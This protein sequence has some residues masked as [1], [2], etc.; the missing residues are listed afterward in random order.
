M[1]QPESPN[2]ALSKR[3]ISVCAHPG[4]TGHGISLFR[5]HLERA[6]IPLKFLNSSATMELTMVTSAVELSVLLAVVRPLLLAAALS[7]VHRLQRSRTR[8]CCS[9]HPPRRMLLCL[10]RCS[11][12]TASRSTPLLTCNIAGFQHLFSPERTCIDQHIPRR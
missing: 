4:T 3:A 12:S 5:Q 1:P 8:G 6:A 2:Y 7:Q 11:T 10:K 9:P